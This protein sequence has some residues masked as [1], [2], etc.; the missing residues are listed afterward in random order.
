MKEKW[1]DLV[2]G[3][4]PEILSAMASFILPGAATLLREFFPCL[5]RFDWN[6]EGW[7][8]GVF[9]IMAYGLGRL[10]RISAGSESKDDSKEDTQKRPDIHIHLIAG[11]IGLT[12]GL[13]P[14]LLF[15]NSCF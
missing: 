8:M 13:V 10:A 9:A 5:M 1:I 7:F 14:T 2:T 11:I 4:S 12:V 3:I 6:S 15:S